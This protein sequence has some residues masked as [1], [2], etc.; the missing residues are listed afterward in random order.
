MFSLIQVTTKLHLESFE[1]KI[2]INVRQDELG[3]KETEQG[4]LVSGFGFGKKFRLNTSQT[5][6]L[7]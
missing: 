2:C 5:Q 1:M 3:A 4:Y 6:I 7:L